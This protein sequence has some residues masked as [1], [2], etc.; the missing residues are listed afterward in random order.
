MIAGYTLAFGQVTSGWIG[1]GNAWMLLHLGNV[2]SGTTVPESAFALFQIA[3]AVGAPALLTGAWAGRA[4]LGWAFTFCTLWSL[5]VLA[6]A[7]HWLW[8][9][10]WLFTS[11]GTLDWA[12]GLTLRTSA[13]VSALVCAAMLGRG[14]DHAHPSA[15]SPYALL[16]PL[17]AMLASLGLLGI[18]AGWALGAN[19]DSSSAII[20]AYAGVAAGTLAWLL[21]GC[22]RRE[23]L[24]AQDLAR[25]VIAASAALS[26]P[27]GYVSPGGAIAI[28]VIATVLARFADRALARS[29]IDDRLGVFAGNAVAGAAGALLLAPFL[30]PTLGGTG[31]RAGMSLVAQLAAQGI[32]ILVITVWSLVMSVILAVMISVIFPMRVSE[33]AELQGLDPSVHTRR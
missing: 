8:G 31:Y 17:G 15:P 27:A 25:A 33:D 26:A 2:R 16:A 14:R 5:A 32:G 13:G 6:P 12:G 21:I 29:P 4:R 3:I 30:N 11:V 24:T 18:S 1:S 19:D 28:G 7:A 20:A 10:G 22:L 9:G 23:P